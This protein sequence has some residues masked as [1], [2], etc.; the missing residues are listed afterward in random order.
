M[1]LAPSL[2][3]DFSY[4]A[5]WADLSD[6]P[7]GPAAPVLDTG[8]SVIDYNAGSEAQAIPGPFVVASGRMWCPQAPT[9]GKLASYRHWK[10]ANGKPVSRVGGLF[11][12]KPYNGVNNGSIG[13]HMSNGV[14][15]LADKNLKLPVHAGVTPT[16][17]TIQI[18]NNNPGWFEGLFTT[19]ASGGFTTP[20]PPNTP[21]IMEVVRFGSTIGLFVS[22]KPPQYATHTNVGNNTANGWNSTYGVIEPYRN[23]ASEGDVEI[24]SYWYGYGYNGGA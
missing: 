22:G 21:F 2:F 8:E 6:K 5:H 13:C 3:T 20:I 16:G 4:P 9:R 7:D 11:S 19:L 10:P 23:N 18:V 17:W 15:N 1:T 24:L 14:I 12:F